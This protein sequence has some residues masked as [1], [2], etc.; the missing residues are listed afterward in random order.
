M[1]DAVSQN[2]ATIMWG[3]DSYP[4]AGSN[5]VNPSYMSV[6]KLTGTL[7]PN[8]LLEAAVNYDGNKIVI[9]P[10]AAGGGS[11]VKPSGWTTGS[12]FPAKNNGLNRLPN[13]TYSTFGTT[14]GPGNDD[15]WHNGAEDYNE[16]FS[17]SWTK[18]TL[19]RYRYDQLMRLGWKVFLPV[20]LGWVVL[21]AAVL[22]FGGWVPKH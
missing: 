2:Y 3:S 5:F 10:V 14:W 12:Y 21:T 1:H 20:S 17:L 18:G 11:F 7:T 4:S 16:F 6:I 22:Q 8:L 15:P 13:F 9:S 19:P